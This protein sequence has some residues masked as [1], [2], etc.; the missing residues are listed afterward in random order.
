MPGLTER[1]AEILEGRGLDLELLDRMGVVTHA[2]RGGDWISIPYHR[3]GSVVNQK[4]RTIAGEK[5]FYQDKD[6]V[7][8][9]WNVDVITDATLAGEPLVICEGEMDAF[10]ALQA[11][12]A[13]TVSVPD[14]APKEQKG[15]DEDGTKYS[16]VTDML[17]ALRPVSV[18]ILA[19]DGDGPG[20]NLMNDLALRLGRAKCRFVRYPA[21]CKD[22][23]DVL[24][25]HGAE[26]VRATLER[27]EW[28]SVKGLYR[29]SELPPLT[30]PAA[31]PLGHAAVDKH[32][33]IRRSDFQ[34]VTGIPNMGK[35]TWVNETACR[36]ARKHGAVT[37]F[38]SPEQRAQIDH[39]RA[40]RHWFIGKPRDEWTAGEVRDADE[41]IDKHFVFLLADDD[42]DA[43]LDW[44]FDTAAAA[45]IRHNAMMISLDPW[46]ELEHQRPAGVSLTEYVGEAIRSLKKFARRFNV[47]MCVTAHPM[48]LQRDRKT[49]EYPVPTL[50]DI[51]D[52][53]HWYNKPDLGVVV[54]RTPEHSIIRVEKV[55]Y[56][57]INGERG[58]ILV[59]FNESSGRF[60]VREDLMTVTARPAD[61]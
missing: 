1:H 19:T 2:E 58:D 9:F 21:G 41:W 23:N 55:R 45:V 34:V 27:A 47:H 35:S 10:I 50:Y 3:G 49:G 11:G 30:D 20:V 61:A 17:D 13:R 29:M 39:K 25:K 36:L 32:I 22:L 53:A 40:L 51:S 6:A 14:G 43:T 12:F 46:N 52:S 31:L 33:R 57:G 59:E 24:V 42:T 26:A 56:N 4:H 5:R 15:A 38:F 28:V 60:Q 7:K 8:C 16:Y 54:H 44:F 48:K 18:I 37:A